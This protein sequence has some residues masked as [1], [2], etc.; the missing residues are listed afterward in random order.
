[1]DGEREYIPPNGQRKTIHK[2]PNMPQGI[3]KHISKDKIQ[4]GRKIKQARDARTS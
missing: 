3:M 4:D 1:M 2:T